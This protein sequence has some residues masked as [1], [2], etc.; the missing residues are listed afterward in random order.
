MAKSL[1]RL[2]FLISTF[3]LFLSVLTEKKAILL[4]FGIILC[5]F[6]DLLPILVYFKIQ[7]YYMSETVI[8]KKSNNSQR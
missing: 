5:I 4:V 7:G 8:A 1:V 3:S 2:F 6:S